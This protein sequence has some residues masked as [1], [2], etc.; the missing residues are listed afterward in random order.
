MSLHVLRPGLASR[1]V[2]LGRPA[3]RSLGVPVGGAVDQSALRLANA[4]LGNDPGAAALEV[5]L[6][7][8]RLAADAE[9]LAVFWG[10]GFELRINQ[11]P[12]P[13]GKS[14]QLQSG[15]RLEVL[16]TPHAT[17]GYLCVAGGVA[18]PA[19]LGS[20][21]AFATIAAGDVLEAAPSR[22]PARFADVPP[23]CAPDSPLRVLPG[24]HAEPR[25]WEQFLT[26][27]FIVLPESDRMGTRLQGGTAI[28]L[29]ATDLTSAP[30]C[31]GTIQ[32]PSGG[33]PIMLG[34][35]AQTIGG[36]PR[37][38]HVVAADLD[39]LAALRPGAPVRFVAVSA[40]TAHELAR[41]RWNWL[42]LWQTR[43]RLSA[44]LWPAAWG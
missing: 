27:E 24:S 7:G 34:R 9:H 14:F 10:Q 18:A 32:L 4:L 26:Q 41:S 3:S 15:D 8:P 23:W 13:V 28:C 33:Q 1:V 2:D 20:R 11:S 12:Y 42:E 44:Q 19:T 37:L 17:C 31:P 36:Y 5:M 16:P 29:A 35:D 25:A 38:G 21:S 39:R 30:V 6:A 43:L 22:G 40:E